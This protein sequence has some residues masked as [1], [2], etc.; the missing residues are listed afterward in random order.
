MASRMV[1]GWGWEAAMGG[2]R[3]KRASRGSRAGVGVW[4]TPLG[5]HC[6]HG[7]D[8]FMPQLPAMATGP[9]KTVAGRPQARRG[10]R[11]GPPARGRCGRTSPHIPHDVDALPA[12][13]CSLI[14][15]P[16]HGRSGACLHGN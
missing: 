5:A 11:G 1:S 15:S 2:L 4:R 9:D 7:S 6:A 3:R 16:C 13:G 10:A 8:V 14:V 12:L